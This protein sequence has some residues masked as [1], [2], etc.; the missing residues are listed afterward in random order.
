VLLDGERIAGVVPAPPPGSDRIDLGGASVAPGLIDLQVNGGGDVLF[1]DAPTVE[2]VR[3][4][5]AAHRRFGTT[6][7]LPTF[8]TGSDDGMAAAARA[9]AAAGALGVHLEG[10][11]LNPARPGVH[12]PALMRRLTLAEAAR[13]PHDQL[14]LLTV[15]PEQ[16]DDG[17][18][19][20]L[21]ARGVRVAAGHTDATH[22]QLSAAFAAGVS[23][24]THLFNAMR[25][26]ESREPGAVGAALGSPDAWCGI[27]LDGHHVHFASARVAWQAKAARKLVLVT[28][29]MPPVG[30]EGTGFRIG[31]HEARVVAG[32]CVTREG[33]LAGSVLD[34]ATTVRN[35][36]AH[37]GLPVE[38]ALRMAS[39]YPAEWLGVAGR[40]GRIAPGFDANLVVFEDDVRVLGT[41]VRGA[42]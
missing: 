39:T 21:S 27:I 7:L 31:P 22:D 20:A 36:V 19:A 30:G 40:L 26:L 12:D 4:I 3:R 13:I 29:A 25:P 6:D 23:G 37:L 18:I 2:S 16:A 38:E 34:M 41:F 35:A 9:C 1:N 8:I 5:A 17:A 33:V 11:F 32:R 15:A 42:N 28:D 10:P 14:V 24:V